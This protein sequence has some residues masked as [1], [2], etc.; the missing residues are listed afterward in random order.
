MKGKSQAKTISFPRKTF[1]E[2]KNI[3]TW[4]VKLGC[5][6][7][8]VTRYEE[9]GMRLNGSF[10]RSVLT[11]KCSLNSMNIL[12]CVIIILR[13]FSSKRELL[14]VEMM[15]TILTKEWHSCTRFIYSL[16]FTL[17]KTRAISSRVSCKVS[18]EMLPRSFSRSL[19][20]TASQTQTNTLLV[21]VIQIEWCIFRDYLG[22]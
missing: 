22:I 7:N 11:L 9:K 18:G 13:V 21:I 2:K 5:Q 15:K 4:D 6:R 1:S 19:I 20:T 17:L 14:E 8:H 10:L 3:V 16:L 12:S